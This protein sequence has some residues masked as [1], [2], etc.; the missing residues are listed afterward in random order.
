M[1]APQGHPW[2]PSCTQTH[3][4]VQIIAGPSWIFWGR[5]GEGVRGQDLADG[6]LWAQGEGSRAGSRGGTEKR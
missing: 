6:H 1:L 5:E 2:L 4:W 3:T